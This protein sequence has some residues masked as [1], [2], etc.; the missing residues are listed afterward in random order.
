MKWHNSLSDAGAW[1]SVDANGLFANTNSLSEGMGLVIQADRRSF[2]F[3]YD[4]VQS[5]GT[6]NFTTANGWT[7]TALS[8]GYGMTTSS[9]QIRF[10][11]TAAV[12]AWATLT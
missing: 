5:S 6:I 4:S 8:A 10:E 9:G 3:M 2:K 12:G 1:I 11:T 7:G